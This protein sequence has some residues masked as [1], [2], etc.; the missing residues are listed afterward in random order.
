MGM[1]GI[2]INDSIVLVTTVDQYARDRGLLPS[3]ID[4]TCD[5][6]RPV[7]LTT[8]TTV[9]G[10]TPLLFERSTQAEFLKP[11]V[12]TLVYG[13]GFGMFIVLLLVPAV[14]A[15]GHDMRQQITSLRRALAQPSRGL[16]L[17]PMVA[18]VALLG[19][20]AATFGAVLAF[21]AL[22]LGLGGF[23]ASPVQGALVL[24]LGGAGLGLLA[25]WIFGALIVWRGARKGQ[26]A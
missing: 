26:G 6:L 16:A 18:G 20:F 24:F 22:P 23:A 13:L 2:I 3:I 8:L 10:L 19:W 17:L 21:G 15:I 9:L 14:L 7:L 11:T 1:I 4:A 5:R 25:A 12:I